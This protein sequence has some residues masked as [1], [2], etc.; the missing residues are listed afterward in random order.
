[1]ARAFE[2]EVEHAPSGDR[3]TGIALALLSTDVGEGKYGAVGCRLVTA[4]NLCSCS[5]MLRLH[6]HVNQSP[7][8]RVFAV[9]RLEAVSF[10]FH[11]ALLN[12]RCA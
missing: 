1:V 8:C 9:S 11:P 12:C 3:R 10:F 6:A 4:M 7:E 2:L 5:V